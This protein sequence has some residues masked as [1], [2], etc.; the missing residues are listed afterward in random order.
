M[1]LSVATLA[2]AKKYTDE[3]IDNV[4]SSIP[5]DWNQND[6]N[7]LDYIKNRP[8][9]ETYDWVEILNNPT[10][11]SLSGMLHVINSCPTLLE[12]KIYKV[13]FNNEEYV[14][15]GKQT[16]GDIYIGAIMDF[17]AGTFIEGEDEEI[18]FNLLNNG[19]TGLLSVRGDLPTNFIIYEQQT[20]V[21]KLD[22]KYIDY[23]IASDEDVLNALIEIDALSVVTDNDNAIFVDENNNILMW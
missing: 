8:F 23:P 7:A 14:C 18:P 15:T 10:I 17:S 3:Q 13:I 16:D 11:N 9:Y 2:L 1:G 22:R 20:V 19:T 5:P 6:E 21:Y 4:S 12:N